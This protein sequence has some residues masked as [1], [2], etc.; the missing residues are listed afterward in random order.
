M[1]PLEL[2]QPCIAIGNDALPETRFSHVIK[3]LAWCEARSASQVGDQGGR[4]AWQFRIA[5]VLEWYYFGFVFYVSVF[6]CEL[7]ALIS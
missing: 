2:L 7:V 6:F 4:C 5:L 3:C 1:D